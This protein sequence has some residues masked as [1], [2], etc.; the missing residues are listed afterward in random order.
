MWRVIMLYQYLLENY[1]EKGEPIFLSELP[2]I[3]KNRISQ[4]MMK[5]VDSGKVKR[6]Q[7][8][9]FYLPY[10]VYG[11]EGGL[12]FESYLQKK[13]I[14][15]KDQVIGY[16]TGIAI[17]NYCGLTSQ[18]EAWYEIKTNRASSKQRKLIVDGRTIVL[19]QP[20]VTITNDNWAALQFLD[21]MTYIDIYCDIS[22]QQCLNRLHNFIRS[23]SLN[24]KTVKKYL[25]YYPDRVYR[26]LYERGIMGELVSKSK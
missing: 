14:K 19:Y 16:Q 25:P 12:N 7:P 6:Y 11:I 20:V 18:N 2:G 5:L 9:V 17:A 24:F 3:S 10:Q 13:Y 1:P 21:L 22:Y 26:N 8:G 4:E 23:R 15:A